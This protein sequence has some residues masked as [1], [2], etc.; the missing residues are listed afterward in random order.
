MLTDVYNTLKKMENYEKW[1]PEAA[2]LFSEIRKHLNEPL[3]TYCMQE[4]IYRLDEA[5]YH[6]PSEG[7]TEKA[8]MALYNNNKF[9]NS[10]E[11]YE[12]VEDVIAD[13]HFYISEIMG[14]DEVLAAYT[15]SS[16][17]TVFYCIVQQNS[18]DIGNA[19]EDTL[20]R[21]LEMGGNE[22]DVQEIMGAIIPEIPEEMVTE[23]AVDQWMEEQYPDGYVNIDL[24]YILPGSMPSILIGKK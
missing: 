9:I 23:E 24:G 20:H 13:H 17:H 19:L 22:K 11:A 15:L 8:T 21:I 3:L 1:H 7:L 4:A 5:G 2:D 6:R 12:T 16:C 10:E 18:T 14:E